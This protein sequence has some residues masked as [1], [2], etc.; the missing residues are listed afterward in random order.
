MNW[1]DVDWLGVLGKIGLVILILLVTWLIAR[2][3]RSGVAK[4]VTKVDALSK[5]GAD[6]RAVGDSLGTIASLLIWLFGLIA[7]LQVFA[8]NEV[9]AP[10]QGMLD[11]FL[12]YLPN[13]VGAGFIFFIGYVIAKILRQLVETALGTVRFDGLLARVRQGTDTV[14]GQSAPAQPAQSGPPAAATNAVTEQMPAQQ[15][16]QPPQTQ[17]APV[18]PPAP[19]APPQPATGGPRIPQIVGNLVFAVVIIVVSIA[20]LQVLGISAISQPAE[21]MLT[22]VLNAIPMILAAA[23]VLGIGYVIAKFVGDLLESTLKGLGTDRAVSSL[24]IVPEGQ[25]ASV[26]ITR[27]AQVAIMVFF[28]IMAARLLDFPEISAILDEILSIG[29]RVVFGGLIIAA[30]FIVAKLIAGAMGAG[31]ASTVIKYA[32]IVLFA[33]MGLRYMGL[34]DSIINLAFGAVV[35]GGALAAA[36]AYGIGGRDA[37]ARSLAKWQAKAESPTPPSP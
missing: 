16:G 5:P 6:G 9:L 29:G 15:H 10:I 37:A 24:G 14:T 25:S 19:A 13:L 2:L 18:Q 26:I 4:L 22:M 21:Q 33:A 12:Q 1:N 35:V 34:A 3:V 11:T 20:A 28:A 8:L 7:V 23:I 30:G 36:L 32:T 17:Q 27:V 31:T